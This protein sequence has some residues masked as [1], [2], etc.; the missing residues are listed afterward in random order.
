MCLFITAVPL[1]KLF[2]CVYLCVCLLLQDLIQSCCVKEGGG[3]EGKRERERALGLLLRDHHLSTSLPARNLHRSICNATK[4]ALSLCPLFPHGS[5][6][7]A[8]MRLIIHFPTDISPSH[9]P[10]LCNVR[11]ALRMGPRGVRSCST[12]YM[13]CLGRTKTC[14][15]ANLR[16]WAGATW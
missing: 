1:I 16:R 3:G 4:L 7:R 6:E 14:R 10:I 9:I 13:I 11:V 2:A 5:E 8:T 15:Y 12:C